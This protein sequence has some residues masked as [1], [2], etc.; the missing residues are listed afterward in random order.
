MYGG[1][2]PKG[3]LCNKVCICMYVYVCT[4]KSRY[5]LYQGLHVR[6]QRRLVILVLRDK[7]CSFWK[8]IS[9]LM[10]YPKNKKFQQLRGFTSNVCSQF[11]SSVMPSLCK[12]QSRIVIVNEKKCK[13]WCQCKFSYFK[14]I[15]LTL[16]EV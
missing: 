10:W 14:V 13:W 8:P 12:L 3:E 2:A 1:R 16:R 5:R 9:R 11:E 15:S 6:L 4:D 7:N